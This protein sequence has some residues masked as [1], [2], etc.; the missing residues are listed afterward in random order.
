MSKGSKWQQKDFSL[1]TLQLAR[2]LLGMEL[3]HELANGII[4]SGRI[5]ET[6]AYLHDDPACHGV[7][8]INGQLQHRQTPRNSPMFGP[9][10]HA[11]IYFTYGNHFLFNI[12]SAETGVPEAV[13][14]R[15]LEPLH[16]QEEMAARRGITEIKSLSNGPGKLTRAL[17]I[18]PS[19]NNHP[20]WQAPLYLLYAPPVNENDIIIT[21]RI[22]I[23]R[24]T[25][26]PWRF[27]IK[28]NP[29]VSKK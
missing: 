21:T 16:G 26:Q 7:R 9:P 6:E 27:Y 20:L 4:I 25:E 11:Y 13:L 28:N 29:F 15:A 5:V 18:S 3:V 1:P 19:Y 8:E 17:G 10:G 2:A 14:I 24:A 22:G 23:T 12:V